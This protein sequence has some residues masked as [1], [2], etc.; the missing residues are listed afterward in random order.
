P[1]ILGK[2]LKIRSTT[3]TVIGVAPG[4]FVGTANPPVVPD[5]WIPL[6]MQ[7]QVI[8][9]DDWLNDALDYQVQ[10]LA[11]LR[12]GVAMKPAEAETALLVQ[13]FANVHPNPDNRTTTVTLQ[14][15][16]FFG[17]TEDPR[18]KAIVVLLMALVGLVLAAACAN[19]ANLL[20]ARVADRHRELA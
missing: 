2:I 10:V 4:A 11:H 5:F 16:T 6:A 20:L 15:A 9:G 17:N 13:Q 3:Y 7:A 1:Q 12:P 8:P 19:L 14:L 18:F